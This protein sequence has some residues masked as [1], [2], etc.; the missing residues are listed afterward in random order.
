MQW[1]I[2]INESTV[3]VFL[4]V[5]TTDENQIRADRFKGLAVVYCVVALDMRS[6]IF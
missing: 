2:I 4:V 6:G 3:R 1:S 5:L